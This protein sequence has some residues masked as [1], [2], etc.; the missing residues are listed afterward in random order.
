[1]DSGYNLTRIWDICPNG[2]L[3]ENVFPLTLTPNHKNLS[4]KTKWRYF[5][6]KCPDTF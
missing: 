4:G 6:G 3:T 1:M 5:S 2:R